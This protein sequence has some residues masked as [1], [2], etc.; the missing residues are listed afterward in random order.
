MPKNQSSDIATMLLMFDHGYA[1][2]I[3][4][5]RDNPPFRIEVNLH[6]VHVRWITLLVIGSIDHNLVKDLVEAR[7]VGN[8]SL[9]DPW[10]PAFD[11]MIIFIENKHWLGE[12]L[13]RTNVG[14]WTEENVLELGLLLIRFFD[15]FDTRPSRTGRRKR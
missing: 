8:L 11:I 14:I 6:P 9:D 2:A 3:I 13:Y 10:R 12:R 5:Y 4:H 7:S 15:C 1:L